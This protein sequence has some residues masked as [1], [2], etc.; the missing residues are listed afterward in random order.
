MTLSDR[1]EQKAA[2]VAVVG[3]GYVGLPLAVELARAGFHVTGLETDP[4]RVDARNATC[5]IPDAAGR[6]IRL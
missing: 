4:E 5:G 6:I 2:R 1:I 3:Q